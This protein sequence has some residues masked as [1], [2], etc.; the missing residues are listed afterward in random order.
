MLD[1][2]RTQDKTNIFCDYSINQMIQDKIVIT[3]DF[4]GKHDHCTDLFEL[5]H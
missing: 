5:C 1:L 3:F 4:I 2:G